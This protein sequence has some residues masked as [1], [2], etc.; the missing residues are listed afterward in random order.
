MK[1]C[2]I[3]CPHFCIG[4]FSASLGKY[5]GAHLLDHMVKVCLVF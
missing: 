4:L 2:A 5:Q 1:N 3:K